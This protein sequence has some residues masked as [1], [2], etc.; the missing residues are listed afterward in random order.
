MIALGLE[1]R[2]GRRW[3]DFYVNS[4]MWNSLLV[5]CNLPSIIIQVSPLLSYFMQQIN[6]KKCTIAVKPKMNITIVLIILLFLWSLSALCEV[7]FSHKLEI[8]VPKQ[9]FVW[10]IGHGLQKEKKILLYCI[11]REGYPNKSES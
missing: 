6:F 1:E 11:H 8:F 3:E 5:C 2:W 9:T 7:Q 10:E 4:S